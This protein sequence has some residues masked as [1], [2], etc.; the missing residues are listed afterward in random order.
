MK[1]SFFGMSLFFKNI[2]LN[3]SN[4]NEQG[5]YNTSFNDNQCY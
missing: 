2:I 1:M 5:S 4:V 3:L